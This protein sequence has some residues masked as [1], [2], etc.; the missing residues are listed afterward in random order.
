MTTKERRRRAAW[1][2]Q[3]LWEPPT[4][5]PYSR[6]RLGPFLNAP[7]PLPLPLPHRVRIIRKSKS[8]VTVL[9]SSLL[10][11][12]IKLG[13]DLEKGQSSPGQDSIGRSGGGTAGCYQLTV[14]KLNGDKQWNFEEL[15]VTEPDAK[16]LLYPQYLFENCLPT[17]SDHSL[18]H[19][20]I[21][22][23]LLLFLF[24]RLGKWL[25]FAFKA[26]PWGGTGTWG[27]I[28]VSPGRWAWTRICN[29]HLVQEWGCVYTASQY[30]IQWWVIISF[31]VHQPVHLVMQWSGFEVTDRQ[32]DLNLWFYQSSLWGGFT[33]ATGSSKPQSGVITIKPRRSSPPA[34]PDKLSTCSHCENQQSWST[35]TGWSCL[36]IFKLFGI[37][38]S[39][40]WAVW[41][42]FPNTCKEWC[43]D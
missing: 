28:S 5:P 19:T 37:Q 27:G 34:I 30:T 23:P 3:T 21:I 33:V 25:G 39:Q 42:R 8:R 32:I 43:T 13:F 12:D 10:I 18:N 41:P 36:S 7:P 14:T 2:P 31:D 16:R 24:S 9:V 1:S 22:V 38:H 4:S 40:W 29:T 6:S 15:E 20:Q 11:L 35:A 17:T 26:T